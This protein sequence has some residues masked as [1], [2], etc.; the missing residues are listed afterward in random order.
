MIR[1]RHVG[2]LP[3]LTHHGRERLEVLTEAALSMRSMPLRLSPCLAAL[4]VASSRLRRAQSEGNTE[5][6]TVATT[7]ALVALGALDANDP[8]VAKWLAPQEVNRRGVLCGG[9]QAVETLR[10]LTIN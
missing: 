7:A 6:A 3:R 9:S 5:A 10:T 1:S 2:V 4:S 8:R